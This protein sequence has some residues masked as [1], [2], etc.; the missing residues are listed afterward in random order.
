MLLI[1]TLAG[2]MIPGARQMLPLWA[3][4]A[5]CGVSALLGIAML[6]PWRAPGDFVAE[7]WPCAV[8]EI[9]VAIPAA[10]GFWLL[11]RRGVLFASPGTGATLAGAG[12][13]LA[14]IPLQ[15]QCMFQQAPHLL[16]W[17][18]GTALLL[19]GLGAAAGNLSRP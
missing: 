6:F 12:V 10:I 7:G 18:V 5:L 4:L 2:Q 3:T 13:A 17:H 14:L 1:A 15:S 16:V 19:V 8:M 11:G 9:A